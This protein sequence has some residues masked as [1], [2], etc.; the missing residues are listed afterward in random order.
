MSTT[1]PGGGR[2]RLN[3]ADSQQCAFGEASAVKIIVTPGHLHLRRQRQRPDGHPKLLHSWPPKLLRA[4]RI[5]YEPSVVVTRRAA[6]SFN[7]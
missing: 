7:R 5:N 2:Y 6:A 4:G 1:L 3:A